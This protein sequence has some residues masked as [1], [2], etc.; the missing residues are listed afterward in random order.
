M[1]TVPG[2][3]KRWP[4]S[5]AEALV[6]EDNHQHVIDRTLGCRGSDD[7]A[8]VSRGSRRSESNHAGERQ[9]CDCR[10]MRN[11]GALLPGI[12]RG[13]LVAYWI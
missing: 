12:H 8:I 7:A 6:L 9:G 10:C 11:T 1:L 4:E 13:L 5:C 3:I 2:L